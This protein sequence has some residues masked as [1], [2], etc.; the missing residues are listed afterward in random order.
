MFDW[1]K[2]DWKSLGLGGF[3]LF[4]LGY[5]VIKQSQIKADSSKKPRR[6]ILFKSETEEE[7]EKPVE[8][9]DYQ[10]IIA[11]LMDII[12][13]NQTNSNHTYVQLSEAI[14]QLSGAI[15]ELSGNQK[16]IADKLGTLSNC[17]NLVQKDM[18]DVKSDV[19][20]IQLDI[21]R[22]QEGINK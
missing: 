1:A 17:I 10:V 20:G 2:V 22:I 21:V 15:Q 9:M 18:D 19:K 8:P 11:K 7:P 5:V 16:D 3:A 12:Q 4:I 6:T 13:T 14:T